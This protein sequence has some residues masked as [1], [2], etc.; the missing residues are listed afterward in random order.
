MKSLSEPEPISP[1]YPIPTGVL[2]KLAVNVLRNKPRSF[3]HDARHLVARLS[4]PIKISGEQFIPRS[5]PCLLTVNHYSRPGFSSWWLALAISALLPMDVHWIITSAWTFPGR[6]YGP[7][8]KPPSEWAFKRIALAYGFSS[9]PP[10]PP[11]ARDTQARTASV[12]HVMNYIRRTPCPVVGLAPE[13]REFPG[14]ILGNPPPG[15]GRF[16]LQMARQGLKIVPVALYEQQGTLC[17]NF[18]AAI[19]P[20]HNDPARSHNDNDDLAR[21]VMQHIA[22]LLPAHLR[23]DYGSKINQQ[24]TA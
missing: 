23:G 2:L 19:Q 24:T 8:L 9:M 21:L 18:G 17:L 15:T 12:R 16:I 14:G 6:W 3:Q 11:D 13:G 10:M 22:A 4:P 1:Y 20:V 7:L 5:G